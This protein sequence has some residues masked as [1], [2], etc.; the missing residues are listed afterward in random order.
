MKWWHRFWKIDGDLDGR[1]EQAV[2]QLQRLEDKLHTTRTS[3]VPGVR[4]ASDQL[5]MEIARALGES[6]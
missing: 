2:Q 6:R 4:R 3:T 1:H 5:A